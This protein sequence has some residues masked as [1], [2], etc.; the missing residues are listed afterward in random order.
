[1]ASSSSSSIV[2]SLKYE[3]YSSQSSSYQQQDST[4]LG[5]LKSGACKSDETYG[6]EDLSYETRDETF[7][8]PRLR[9]TV[10]ERR[11]GVSSPF[12]DGSEQVPD[13][14]IVAAPS[15]DD[16]L[17]RIAIQFQVSRLNRTHQIMRKRART[18]FFSRKGF[19][20]FI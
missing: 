12:G 16:E 14:R 5:G 8:V 11:S 17:L 13:G 20:S 6:K 9:V 1:L 7:L 19:I 18:F 3:A 15:V 2:L 4:P 10:F